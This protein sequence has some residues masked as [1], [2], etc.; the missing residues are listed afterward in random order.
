MPL[1][2]GGG[3]TSVRQAKEIISLGVEKIALSSA[4]IAQPDLVTRIADALGRQSVVVVLDVKSTLFGKKHE[5]WTHNARSN[6]RR[7]VIELAELAQAH[8]AGE[9][10]INSIDHD[11]QMKGY[12]LHLAESVKERLHVPVTFLGG[13][14][15]LIHV[16][17]LISACGL[18]GAAAG[19]LF[20]FKGPYR[21]VLI[22][23]PNP[24]QKEQLVR[25][26]LAGRR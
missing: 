4:F 1:C 26:G 14:G 7:S 2:Y 25:A 6:T 21:A 17:E 20:V 10:V 12:D 8:G 11:G 5:V 24:Q 16:Q 18:V 9:V 19:S 15:S 22:N 3:I 13:A 23:Y